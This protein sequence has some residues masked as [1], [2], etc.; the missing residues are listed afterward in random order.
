MGLFYGSGH[1]FA[2]DPCP[3]FSR[4]DT[5]TAV[6]RGRKDVTRGIASHNQLS[7]KSLTRSRVNGMW[8]RRLP[9]I[10]ANAFAIAG[11]TSTAPV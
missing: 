10:R 6:A 9:V 5:V 8:R 3:M 1:A 2:Q 4:F 11:A 7:N